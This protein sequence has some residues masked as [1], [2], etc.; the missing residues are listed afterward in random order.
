MNQLLF[1]YQKL[2]TVSSWISWGFPFA[3]CKWPMDN[4]AFLQL[5]AHQGPDL[6]SADSHAKPQLHKKHSRR[7]CMETNGYLRKCCQADCLRTWSIC[8]R[9]AIWT[10]SAVLR[11]VMKNK[12]GHK[13]IYRLTWFGHASFSKSLRPEPGK[14]WVLPAATDIEYKM[15]LNVTSYTSYLGI[16]QNLDRF[17]TPYSTAHKSIL[18]CFTQLW[19]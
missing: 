14:C 16:T 13:N 4:Q 7:R 10:C 9:S 3:L 12:S 2:L 8:L 18:C 1:S 6:C 17:Q 19:I 15:H 5:P 11:H